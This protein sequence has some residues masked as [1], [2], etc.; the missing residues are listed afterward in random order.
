MNNIVSYTAAAT[1]GPNNLR[2]GSQ[3]IIG[4]TDSEDF[5]ETVVV[6]SI[7]SNTFHAIDMLGSITEYNMDDVK[8]V[9]KNLDITNIL[10]AL[11]DAVVN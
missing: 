10:Q 8:K 11:V 6:L 7:N 9:K 2:I 4:D 1:Y 5:D 3:I